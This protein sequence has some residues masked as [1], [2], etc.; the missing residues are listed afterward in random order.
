MS[1][2]EIGRQLRDEC[3]SV[4]LKHAE[5]SVHDKHIDQLN[6]IVKSVVFK[7]EM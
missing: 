7:S 6:E 4:G 3:K 5:E 2:E 1:L